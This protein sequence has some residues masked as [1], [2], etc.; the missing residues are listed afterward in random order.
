VKATVDK[1]SCIGCEICVTNCPEG[2]EMDGDVAKPKATPLPPEAEECAKQAAE[3][4]P[5]DSITIE[6]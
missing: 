3:D 1:D 4:C 5:T 6:E 2:F